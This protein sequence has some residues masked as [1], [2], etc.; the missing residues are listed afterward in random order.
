MEQLLFWI[1]ASAITIQLLLHFFVFSSVAFFKKESHKRKNIGI[2]VLVCAKNEAENLKLLLPSIL[3]Q[4]YPNFEVLLIN[5][6]S[7]DDSLDLMEHYAENYKNVKVVNVM[8]NDTFL[9]S[10]KYALTLGIKASTNDYLLFTDAD[11]KP[12]SSNWITEMSSHFSNNKTIVIGYGAYKTRKGFLN[13]IIRFETV[14]TALHYL[15]FAKLGMPYMAVGRNLAYR[16][17]EF[18][19]VNGF[20]KHMN[21]LSGDDDL[22]INEI[23]T[24]ENSTICLHSDSFTK[25]LPKTSFRKWLNQKKRHVSTSNF[26]K[27]HHKFILGLSYLSNFISWLL[28]IILIVLCD[29]KLYVLILFILKMLVSYIIFFKACNT[30][31]EKKL[32]PFLLVLEPILIS[33]QLVIFMANLSSKQKRWN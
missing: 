11:C 13:K 4:D 28:F 14:I 32:A 17:D 23:A 1:F 29:V 22:F 30:L 10:K 12:V 24:T 18:F 31:N 8:P 5:D 16:K 20:T 33:L 15:G 25:S 6:G 2:S 21:I 7:G 26:Y 9:S 3:E 19:K 27:F